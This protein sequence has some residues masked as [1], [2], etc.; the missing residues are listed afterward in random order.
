MLTITFG[1]V[2]SVFAIS[3]KITASRVPTSTTFPVF[4]FMNNQLSKLE[5]WRRRD[6]QDWEPIGTTS[7]N[8]GTFS[9]DEDVSSGY[10]YRV[11][12]VAGSN[13]SAYTSTSLELLTAGFNDQWI[14]FV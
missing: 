9:Y 1:S 2:K 13:E 6:Q 4:K 5:F 3:S 14:H 11:K 7:A 12:F 8:A 10:L